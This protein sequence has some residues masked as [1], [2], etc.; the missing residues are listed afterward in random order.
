MAGAD[1]KGHSTTAKTGDVIHEFKSG[2]I[3]MLTDVSIDAAGNVWA[4]NNWNY[5]EAA[6]SPNPAWAT[7]TWGGR[8]GISIIYGVASPVKP[9]CMGIVRKP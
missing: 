6:A 9:P 4:A 5:P 7:S 8:S 3:Q 2:N 1:T